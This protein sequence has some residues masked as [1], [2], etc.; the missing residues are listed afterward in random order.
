MYNVRLA[1]MNHLVLSGFKWVI[2][3][4]QHNLELDVAAEAFFKSTCQY[5][6]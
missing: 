4:G 6:N 2:T 3:G 5:V 1:I